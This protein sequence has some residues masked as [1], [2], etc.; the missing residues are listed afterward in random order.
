MASPGFSSVVLAAALALHAPAAAAQDATP[1]PPPST[2]TEP[3]APKLPD[4]ESFQKEFESATK[5][6]RERRWKEAY[7]A[8][9][10]LLRRHES[11][12]YVRARLVEI[13]EQIKKCSFW[14]SEREPQ[15][16]GL[17]SGELL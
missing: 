9:A 15:A 2:D 8:W 13:R 5:A 14:Q 11:A 16:R 1:P 10:G 4:A 12:P 6:T 3:Q 7:A 17:V